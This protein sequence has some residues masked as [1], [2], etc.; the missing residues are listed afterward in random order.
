M[1]RRGPL[2]GLVGQVA[3]LTLL[4]LTLGIGIDGWLAGS[5]YG[6]VTCI[7]LS[8]GL[9]R[10]GA[11]G[12][13][14]ADQVTLV[15]ATLVGGVAAL[16]THSL[17]AEVPAAVVV[18]IASVALALDAVDGRVARR[19]G[20][21]SRLGA[22]FDMEV[23]AFLILVLSV[24]VAAGLGPWVLAIGAMR[25]AYVVAGWLLPWLRRP[26]PPRHWRKAVAA[27]QGIT[28]TVATS[29][30]LPTVV[31]AIAVALALGLLVESFG[32]DVV[33]L[34]RRPLPQRGDLGQNRV[35]KDQLTRF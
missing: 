32:H 15:R 17:R 8:Y 14:R 18:A 22:R 3:V 35:V 9:H 28:L 24:S 13:G 33:H 25:Y 21:A 34:Y 27:I 16:V 10:A 19:T 29:G 2:I 30:L 7:A 4:D 12:L 5:A 6:L 26:V 20:T 1:V 31:S 11:P 23:D